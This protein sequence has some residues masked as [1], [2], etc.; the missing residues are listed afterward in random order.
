MLDYF[1]L[2]PRRRVSMMELEQSETADGARSLATPFRGEQSTLC[3]GCPPERRSELLL[4]AHRLPPTAGWPSH[5]DAISKTH[6]AKIRH[7]LAQL[8][9]NRA[10]ALHGM[11]G[12]LLQL[13]GCG[14]T[15]ARLTAVKLVQ[16]RVKVINQ[17]REC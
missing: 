16:F 13:V 6:S 11:Q 17:G 8:R 10:G 12:H 14:A 4:R 7:K 1:T 15:L 5:F 3:V 9:T 2:D